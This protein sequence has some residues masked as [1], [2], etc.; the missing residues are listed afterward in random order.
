MWTREEK[1]TDLNTKIFIQKI[2]ATQ[3]AS[4]RVTFSFRQE[5]GSVVHIRGQFDVF[6]SYYF[7]DQYVL[8]ARIGSVELGHLQFERFV[9]SLDSRIGAEDQDPTDLYG[10]DSS[11]LL[12]ELVTALEED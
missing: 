1:L 2:L 4:E 3:Q 7:G 6:L 12:D 8:I 5:K 10:E 9:D 11:K